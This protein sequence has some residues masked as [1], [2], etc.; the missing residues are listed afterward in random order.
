MNDKEHQQGDTT[1]ATTQTIDIRD[2]HISLRHD[3]DEERMA[4][5]VESLGT[6][7]WQGRPVVMYRES[8]GRLINITGCHRIEAACRVGIDV[9]AV[10]IDA[11]DLD[12]L[13]LCEY[14]ASVDDFDAASALLP[15]GREL[16]DLVQQ[17]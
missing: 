7:G 5:L 11:S 3:V 1:I 17:G 15:L 12:T 16:H 6:K 9:P 2:V 13:D 10:I 8:D 14:A 4:P